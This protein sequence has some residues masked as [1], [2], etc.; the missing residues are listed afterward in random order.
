MKPC[1][2]CSRLTGG[3]ICWRCAALLCRQLDELPW[4]LE[5]L[6]E[7][8]YGGAKLARTQARTQGDDSTTH[9][10]FNERAAGLL[11][12]CNAQLA[13][14]YLETHSSDTVPQG[15]G[16]ARRL[17]DEA[18]VLMQYRRAGEMLALLPDMLRE[19]EE[20]IDLP[21]SRRLIGLCIGCDGALYAVD[22]DPKATCSMC[23]LAMEVETV[24]A[25]GVAQVSDE[26]RPAADLWRLAQ[27]T[28][29]KLSR[30]TFYRIIGSVEPCAYS[31]KDFGALYRWA[32]VEDTLRQRARELVFGRAWREA[33]AENERRAMLTCQHA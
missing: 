17:A 14:W 33:H 10:K 20:A 2:H 25:R 18:R 5:Q 16:C 31:M 8:A 19:C 26:P 22:D 4:Y 12:R 1:E 24:R 15:F 23:G 28:G 30:A 29:V 3:V 9:V 7:A 21:A 11:M 32:D 27:W 13:R 6:H